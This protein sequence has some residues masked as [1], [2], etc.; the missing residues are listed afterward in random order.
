M[1]AGIISRKPIAIRRAA[2]YRQ[3]AEE[4][5]ETAREERREDVRRHLLD[6]AA[7]FQRAADAMAP[8]S[9][10]DNYDPTRTTP[11]RASATTGLTSTLSQSEKRV[12]PPKPADR[13]KSWPLDPAWPRVP[14]A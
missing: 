13:E 14:T 2:V 4:L 11:R 8:A 1:P 9:G 12:T 6:Q 7:T 3:R 5:T 10:E